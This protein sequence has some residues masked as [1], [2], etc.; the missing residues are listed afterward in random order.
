MNLTRNQLILLAAGASAALLI[1]AYT[2]QALGYPPCKMCWW[3][4]YPHFAAVGIG[5]L[6]LLTRGPVLPLLGALAAA[7]TSGIGAYHS[8]VERKWWEGPSSCTS[9]GVEGLSAEELMDQ[10]LNAPLVLCDEIP[11]RL[12]D[13]IPWQ[14]LDIT[15]AQL[16]FLGSAV[17]AVIWIMAARRS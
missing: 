15:M 8:G 14:V 11:W 9:S 3:Q 12:S 5:A 1:G 10:I 13:M 4:R 6:A 7:I 2:F 17:F 16:N